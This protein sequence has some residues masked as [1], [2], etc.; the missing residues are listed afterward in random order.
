MNEKEMILFMEK[1]TIK[2]NKKSI[3]LMLILY[4]FIW[5]PLILVFL[6]YLF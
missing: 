3:D 6:K 4:C 2:M 1:E 5:I